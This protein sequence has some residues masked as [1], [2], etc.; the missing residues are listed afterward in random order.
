MTGKFKKQDMG[1]V[2][3]FGTYLNADAY[4]DGHEAI[5]FDVNSSFDGVVEA[6]ADVWRD[7][8]HENMVSD[9]SYRVFRVDMCV[10]SNEPESVPI[11]VTKDIIDVLKPRYEV[12]GGFAPAFFYD[13]TASRLE[14]AMEEQAADIEAQ[15]EHEGLG[16]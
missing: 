8:Q 16:G 10:K 3:Y 4:G 9:D 1:K 11:E 6:C 13:W 15:I 7:N 12:D 14:D 5:T 2:V